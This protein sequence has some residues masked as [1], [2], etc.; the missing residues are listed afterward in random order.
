MRLWLIEWPAYLWDRFWFYYYWMIAIMSAGCIIVT[1]VTVLLWLL[2][3]PQ[4]QLAP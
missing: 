4:R 3:V 2:G 1:L